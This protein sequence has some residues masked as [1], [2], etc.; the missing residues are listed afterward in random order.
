MSK[1]MIVTLPLLLVLL[2]QWPLRRGLR[3]REKL[4]LFALSGISAVITLMAQKGSGALESLTAIPFAARVENCSWRDYGRYLRSTRL[5]LALGIGGV[6][7]VSSEH[8]WN[9]GDVVA[10]GVLGSGLYFRCWF[11][12]AGAGSVGIFLWGGSGSSG[13]W[14]RRSGWCRWERRRMRIAIC[15]SPWWAF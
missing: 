3:L 6:L 4:P 12:R 1:P 13:L 7:S 2:D 9:S 11:W 14:F 8:R 15:T 10:A 5:P